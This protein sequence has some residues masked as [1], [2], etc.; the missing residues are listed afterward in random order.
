M[1]L[2]IWKRWTAMWN[3]EPALARELVA[4]RF[5]LHL[6]TPSDTDAAQVGDPAAVERWVAAHLAHFDRA[7]Y[8]YEAGP[9]VDVEAGVV[10]SPWTATFT[11]GERTVHVC[12]MD[13]VRFRDGKVVEY[14]TLARE[15]DGKG[16][17]AE[18]LAEA[19]PDASAETGAKKAG[20]DWL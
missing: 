3:G 15:S 19:A 14:W 2:D 11:R 8:A 9:F 7:V 17:W 4:P 6:P 13:T 18:P 20:S 1:G 12:G 10:A 16:R 5:A